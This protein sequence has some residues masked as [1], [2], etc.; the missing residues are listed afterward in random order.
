MAK[1]ALIEMQHVRVKRGIREVFSDLSLT[2]PP[3]R[4]SAVIGPNG[5]GKSTLLKLICREL[6]PVADENSRFEVLGQSAWEIDRL[7]QRMGVV[8]QELQSRVHKDSTVLQVVVSQF[9]SSL[10][11]WVH[12]SYSKEQIEM[13]KNLIDFVGIGHLT[14]NAFAGLSTGEQRRCL[15]ARALI[16]EPEYLILDEPTAGL[17]IRATHQYMETMSS[18][19]AAGKKLILVTHHLEEIL[20]QI[21][22]FVFLKDGQVFAQGERSQLLTED[23]LSE[24]FDI[25]IRLEEMGGRLLANTLFDHSASSTKEK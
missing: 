7:R 25:P 15:L 19:I 21:D 24:L 4:S 14:Q 10:T 2:L 9:Y 16:H 23:C 1:K 17:D 3:D 6:Y 12:Q 13:A 5:A 20:P 11:T 22:W 18:L 8:S